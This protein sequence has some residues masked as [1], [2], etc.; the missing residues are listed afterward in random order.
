MPLQQPIDLPELLYIFDPLCGWCYG[1]SPV[2]QRARQEFA[3]RVDVSVLCGGMVTSEQAGPIRN[4]WPY[5]SGT[6]QQVEKVTGVAFGD[7]FKTLGEEGSRVQ[8]SEPPSRAI[9]AFRQLNQ[10]DTVRFAHDIQV[11]YFRDGA[12]LNDPQTYVPLATAYDVDGADFLHRL[13][14]T[15]TAQATRQEFA[16]VAKLGVQGFP[17]A[18]LRIGVQGY[19]L[20][21]GYQP[22]ETFAEGL[23]QALE[24]GLEQA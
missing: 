3:G 8:N 6:L 10:P 9:V 12:D 22:Y 19:V 1:M 17:M 18:V 24:Q 15:E 2:I 14:L 13:M 7:A 5:I 23:E 21:S 4:D 11:V 16:A 20:A